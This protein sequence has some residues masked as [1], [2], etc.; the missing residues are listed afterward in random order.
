MQPL[1]AF[2]SIIHH[3]R[4]VDLFIG[5]PIGT[6]KLE[7]QLAMADGSTAKSR[8]LRDWGRECGSQLIQVRSL[9]VRR[10]T[11]EG[12][13]LVT[14]QQ[15]CAIR[16]FFPPWTRSPFDIF[17]EHTAEIGF[18]AVVSRCVATEVVGSCC[19]LEIFFVL[20]GSWRSSLI[21][22]K[23]RLTLWWV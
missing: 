1:N 20:V 9:R 17:A 5:N 23:W 7:A 3:W 21:Y 14:M 12:L 18:S 16:V 4:L 10:A 8:H 6:P 13:G 11:R 19:S 2:K 22:T 15:C